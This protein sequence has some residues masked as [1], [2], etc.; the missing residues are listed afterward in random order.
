MRSAEAQERIISDLYDAASISR[1]KFSVSLQLLDLTKTV[2]KA[3]VNL[4]ITCQ[5]PQFF[6][7][8]LSIFSYE[9]YWV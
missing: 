4:P 7:H 2:E 5:Y 6:T 3:I 8:K 1:G 9:I